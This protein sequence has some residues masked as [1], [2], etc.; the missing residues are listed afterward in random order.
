MFEGLFAEVLTSFWEGISDSW[1]QI[2]DTEF[3]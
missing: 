3:N 1:I 2:C